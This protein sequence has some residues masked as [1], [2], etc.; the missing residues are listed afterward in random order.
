MPGPVTGG[1]TGGDASAANQTAQSTLLGAVA[2]TAPASDVASSGLNGRLQRLAQRLTS[3]IALFPASIGQKTAAGSLSVTVASDQAAMPVALDAPSLAALENISVTVTSG[4]VVEITNDA[5]NAIPISAASL[6]LPTGAASE[7]TLD[8]RSGSLTETAPSTDT[9]SSGLNG[10]LQRLAQRLTSLI[11]QLPASLG[12]KT[13]A[14]SL[15]VTSASDDANIAL[16]GAV[17]E[18]SPATD[19]AASGQNGRLQRI[20]QRI[21]S[22]IAQIP[23]S[24]GQKTMAN[25]LAVTIASDQGAVPI[26]NAGAANISV[27]Q[28]ALSTTAATAVIARATRRGVMLK[29]LDTAIKIYF[30]PATVTA[31]N[32]MELKPGESAVINWVGLVQAIAASGTPTLAFVDE[33]D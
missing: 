32:G 33:Y 18:T 12:A 25:S 30:G 24:L 20:A 29:N 6:P 10:R 22:L 1:G 28:V 17:N 11:A 16:M 21:T 15:S 3:F 19:T 31:A 14:A 5:G 23:A 9:G 7:A 2:E 4:P 13:A 26:N 8:A 27:N